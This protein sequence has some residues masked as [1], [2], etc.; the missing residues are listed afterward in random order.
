MKHILGFILGIS[1]CTAITTQGQEANRFEAAADARGGACRT[2]SLQGNFI[3]AQ[4]GFIISGSEATQRTPFAQVGRESYDGKGVVTGNYTISQNGK[5]TRA[6]YVGTYSLGSDCIG[7]VTFTD[8]AGQ[9]FHYDIFV[10][11]A[12]DEF[13]FIQTDANVVSA[14]YERRKK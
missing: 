14:A 8:S 5:V 1:I 12:G 4:N 10:A 13:S 9:T 3:Y 11:D 7:T 2:S 6:H